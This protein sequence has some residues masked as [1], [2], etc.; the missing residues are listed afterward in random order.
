MKRALL[1]LVLAAAPALGA[2][3]S[4]VLI[5]APKPVAAEVTK[6]LKAKHN[7][8]NVTLSDEPTAG[9]VKN[10]CL[11][12]GAIAIV[13]ARQAGSLMN[14]M[15]LNCADGGPLTTFKLTWGKKPPKAFP[16]PDIAVL[17]QA[18]AEAKPAKKEA[19]KPPPPEEK[20]AE[21]SKPAEEKPAE[22][23]KP[24]PEE[25]KKRAEPSAPPPPPQQAQSSSSSAEVQQEVVREEPAGS[26]PQALR[27]GV[28]FKAFSRLFGYTD[29]L[30]NRLSTYKLPLGPALVIDA[31]LYPLAF[32]T[33]G[34]LSGVGI[35]AYFDYAV[36]IASRAADGTK[37]GTSAMDLRISATFRLTLGPLT[38]NPFLGY[39]MQTYAISASTGGTKPNIP[40]VSYG[41]FRGGGMLTFKVFGPISVQASLA[42]QL[43]LGTGEIQTYFPH[44]HAGGMDVQF[45]IPVQIT[46][47]IQVKAQGEYQRFW[48]SMNPMVGDANV[49]G[50]ALD[51][52]ASGTIVAAFTL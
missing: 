9:D 36:G 37:Y 23:A 11:E 14:F 27:L 34:I 17:N 48:Y 10:A 43:I 51:V 28:G 44:L 4:K 12:H 20:P 49:A 7:T 13:T 35:L 19:A 41:A 16:K 31:D 47:R 33:R 30:F 52:Y 32:L 42:G 39:G 3:K 21:T 45:A 38:I 15:V 18:I 5:D 22:T 1:A 26:R 24:P 8:Q 46:D 2:A 6:A 29:D 50:G 25:K 40:N